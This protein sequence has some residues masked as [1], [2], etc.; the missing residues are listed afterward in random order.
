ML[1]TGPKETTIKHDDLLHL[2]QF[3]EQIQLEEYYSL[4]VEK[5]KVRDRIK[6]KRERTKRENERRLKLINSS[7]LHAFFWSEKKERNLDD[8]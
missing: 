8:L 6:K 2:R 4:I 1:M 5:L 3:L 7:S